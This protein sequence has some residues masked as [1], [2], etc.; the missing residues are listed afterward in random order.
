V[1]EAPANAVQEAPAN[2]YLAYKVKQLHQQGFYKG[3]VSLHGIIDNKQW[4][5]FA[6]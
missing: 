3:L 6:A 2:A 1:Q 4:L 5:F